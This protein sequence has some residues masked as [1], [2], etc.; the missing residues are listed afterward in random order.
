ML[1]AIFIVFI[2]S[3]NLRAFLSKKRYSNPIDN[4]LDA[5][6]SG[7]DVYIPVAFPEDLDSYSESYVGPAEA[8]SVRI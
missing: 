5:L 1:F 8:D 2:Y 7:L 4:D 3:S 6:E